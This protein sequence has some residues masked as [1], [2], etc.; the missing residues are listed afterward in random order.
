[1]C[2]N[3]TGELISLGDDELEMVADIT[4]TLSNGLTDATASETM[5]MQAEAVKHIVAN[6]G[7]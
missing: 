6:I 5:K 1:M 3:D 7:F 2:D 4:L